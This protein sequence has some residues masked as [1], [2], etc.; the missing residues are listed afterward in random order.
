MSLT[1]RYPNPIIISDYTPDNAAPIFLEETATTSPESWDT[2]S[3]DYVLFA[4][5]A[6]KI[7]DISTLF[8]CGQQQGA[9]ALWAQ[10]VSSFKCRGEFIYTFTVNYK[11]LVS[12][13]PV[14]TDY[15]AAAENQNGTNILVG[16]TL[17]ES[18][19]T[20]ENTPTAVV[21]YAV[22]DKST[23]GTDEV[24]T[25]QTPA[26]APGVAAS[27][28]A[29]LNRFTYHYPNGWVLMSSQVT[30]LPGTSAA[31]V[32]DTYQFIRDKTPR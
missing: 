25:A 7:E 3:R 22:A 30:E 11:G 31:L 13:H 23:V 6:R 27:V 32:A 18:L 24:G 26:D 5:S 2:V 21:R 28:W 14:I 12:A 16:P 9:R 1:T 29:F 10:T 15:G 20:H 4:E 17:Y 19:S 8:P